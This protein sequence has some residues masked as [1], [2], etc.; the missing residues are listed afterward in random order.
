ML[1]LIVYIPQKTKQTYLSEIRICFDKNLTLI[2]CDGL[3]GPSD[4]TA[5]IKTNCPLKKTIIYPSTIPSDY[6][7]PFYII[8]SPMYEQHSW[9]LEALQIIQFLQWMTF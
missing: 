3:N 9:L 7:K 5:G 4:Q 8:T 1:I 6:E 2:D